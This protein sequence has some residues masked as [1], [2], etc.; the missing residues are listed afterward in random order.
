MPVL[1]DLKHDEF[2][3]PNMGRVTLWLVG[4]IMILPVVNA[5]QSFVIQTSQ[6]DAWFDCENSW[7]NV[8]DEQGNLLANGSDF[9]ISLVDGNHTIVVEDENSCQ[10]VIPVTEDLPNQRPAPSGTFAALNS[11]ICNQSDYSQS[12]CNSTLI[13]G[14]VS[15]GNDDVFAIDVSAND[16][17]SLNLIAAS[18]S[19]DISIHFQDGVSE[20]KLENELTLALNTS[21]GGEYELLI[22][23]EEN[24]RLVVTVSSPHQDTLW[25]MTSEIFKTGS[26]STL[27]NIHQI[28]GIGNV[29]YYFELGNDESIIVNQSRDNTNDEGLDIQ[30][31]YAFTETSFSSWSNAS[32]GDRI[33]GIDNIERVELSWNC[34][35]EWSAS[36]SHHTHFDADWNSDAPGFKPLSSTS[37]NSSYPLITMDGSAKD[38]ELTLHKDDYQDVLRVETT[39]W[40]E[41][42]HLVDVVVEGDVYDLEVSI[43]NMD[44]ETWDVLDEITATYSMDKIRVTLDVGLGTH[45]IKIQHKNGTSALDEN[46][47]SLQWKIR[48]TTA[49]LDEGDEPWFP[50]SDAVKEAAN[51]FY[52][53]IGLLLILPFIIFY[54]NV[55][56]N[57]KF[58]QEF[59][60]KKN[61]LQWLTERLDEGNFSPLE[62]SKAL[63][64]VSS[65]EW[66]ES[67]EVWGEPEIRHYTT[68]IDMAVWTLD[69]R[70]GENGSW[71]I[72]IGLRPQDCEW[73]VAALKFEANQG[74]DWNV[75]RVEP[76]L[77][78]RANEIFLDTIYSNSRVFI[79]VDLAGNSNSVDIYL[80]GMVDGE[81]IAAKPANTIY[82]DVGD[83][84][85]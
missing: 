41:S 75:K 68:G 3:A 73:S 67:L 33:H 23:V 64:S 5:D 21:I 19:I 13:S 77:L 2:T 79:R 54:V 81:P 24:G 37:D 36:L 11:V 12:Q 78:T 63:K 85:E 40:N 46:A 48:V 72:L 66:E 53:L 7:A 39:G 50:A 15:N 60:R 76:K 80:S 35:C 9:Q 4:L 74:S 51:V 16:I 14:N 43:L 70:L 61:R 52:W 47:T 83:S 38:G 17:V 69:N 29:T 57:K 26:Q 65:L 8:T 82:R 6:G 25:M 10:W 30:Y 55:N 49:V 34:A 32:I 27:D 20:I 42:I 28:T 22:P 84:E 18:S 31:R 44:Q 62:L 45:F 59:A 58:A 56:N 71:P 1:N